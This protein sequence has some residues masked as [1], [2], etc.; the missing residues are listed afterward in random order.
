MR[1]ILLSV[2]CVSFLFGKNV[3][4]DNDS[5]CFYIPQKVLEMGK[6]VPALMYLS[7]TGAKKADL[8]SITFIADSLNWIIFSCQKSR[9]HRDV[10][11][12]HQDIIK[13]YHKAIK[14]YPIDS[15]R[16]F[17][18]GFSGQ[19]VQ[20]MMSMFLRPTLFRGLISEC[21][22]S[23]ALSLAKWQTLKGKLVYLVTRNKDWN[24]SHNYSLHE[25]FY[26][27]G[28]KDTLIIT[29]GEHSIGT[30]K[31]LFKAVKWLDKY[32]K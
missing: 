15:T 27:H 31:D 3:I 17:I 25:Q 28:I 8:D 11:L 19:G 32:S 10:M 23:G 30:A 29:A 1:I 9:N 14:S 4:C 12:N 2:V 26:K 13:T 6:R 5:D 7:C 16:V 24:L 18:Y 22:H 21:A 20:A